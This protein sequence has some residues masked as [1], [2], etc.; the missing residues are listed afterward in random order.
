MEVR[1]IGSEYV[2]QDA[3]WTSKKPLNWNLDFLDVGFLLVSDPRSQARL[4]YWAACSNDSSS[5]A[6]ILFKAIRFGIAFLIGVKVEDFGRFK[7][8]DVSDMDRLV[9]H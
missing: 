9:G 6:A 4:R 2:T 8:E 3:A 7:P 5:M 1:K